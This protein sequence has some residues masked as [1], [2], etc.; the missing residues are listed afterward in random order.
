MLRAIS[1]QYPSGQSDKQLKLNKNKPFVHD[2][3]FKD[4]TLHSVQVPV[5]LR[6]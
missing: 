5:Q 1:V 2:V 6:H 3:Q 4:D